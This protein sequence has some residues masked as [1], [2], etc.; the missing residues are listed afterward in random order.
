VRVDRTDADDERLGHLRVGESDGDQSEDI[1]LTGCQA[2]P[3]LT[4]V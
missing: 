2:C 3:D 4:S 1:Y